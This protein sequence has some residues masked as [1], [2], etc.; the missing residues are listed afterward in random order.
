[1]LVVCYLCNYLRVNFGNL[2]GSEIFKFNNG[3]VSHHQ[4]VMVSINVHDSNMM[5]Y[6]NVFEQI[7]LHDS[8]TVIY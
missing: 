3:L 4:L 5:I 8:K 6:K 2:L 7:K 1:M